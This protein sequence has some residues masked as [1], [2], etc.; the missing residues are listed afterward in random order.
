[1][2][3]NS[4]AYRRLTGHLRLNG[5]SAILETLEGK[6]I[7]ITSSDDLAPFQDQQVVVEGQLSRADRLAL[8]WIALAGT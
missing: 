5:H 8:T 3:G 7:Y 2:V 6:L 1:M 4:N